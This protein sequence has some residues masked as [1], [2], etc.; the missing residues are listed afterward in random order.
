MIL[1][2]HTPSKLWK[3]QNQAEFNS[4]SSLCQKY[5]NRLYIDWIMNKVLS[6]VF[7]SWRFLI[8]NFGR[9]QIWT[10]WLEWLE[11]CSASSNSIHNMTKYRRTTH[12]LPFFAISS[13]NLCIFWHSHTK[14]GSSL[15][16]TCIIVRG[17]T[18]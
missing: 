15:C 11:N 8:F 9:Y 1:I 2:T 14:S 7:L 5:K 18:K 16:A 12:K 3:N 6:C 13:G 4:T 10:G 17:W